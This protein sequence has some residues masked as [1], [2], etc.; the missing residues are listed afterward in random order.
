M[1]DDRSSNLSHREAG[2]GTAGEVEVITLPIFVAP[3]L[4]G[5]HN[6]LRP[7]IDPIACWK[8]EDMLFEFNSSFVMPTMASQSADLKHLMDKHRGAPASVYGHTDPTGTDDFNKPLSG[9][10]AQAVYGMLTRRIDLWEELFTKEGWGEDAVDVML[11]ALGFE[12]IDHKAGVA[13]FQKKTGLTAS[14]NADKET[15]AELFAQ[16]MDFVCADE[17]GTPFKLD[18]T[19]F[20]G[21]G[22]DIDGKADYQGCSEFNPVLVFSE[23]EDSAFRAAPD[24]TERDKANAPNRR[25][26][27]FLFRKGSRIDPEEWPCPRVKEGTALCKKRFWSDEKKRRQLTAERREFDTTGDTFACRFYER[28]STDSPCDSKRRVFIDLQS[29]DELGFFVPNA[30]LILVL[31]DGSR[32]NVRTDSSGYRHQRN[33]PEGEVRILLPDGTAAKFLFGRELR[34]AVLD[35]SVANKTITRVV[36]KF[37]SKGQRDVLNEQDDLH[38]RKPVPKDQLES[39][40][41]ANSRQGV[42]TSENGEPNP[43]STRTEGTRKHSLVCVDNLTM[44]AA[45]KIGFDNVFKNERQTFFKVLRQWLGDRHPTALGRGYYVHLLGDQ[46]MTTCTSGGTQLA[47]SKLKRKPAMPMGAYAVFED[48]HSTL[49]VDMSNLSVTA[50]MEEIPGEPNDLLIDEIVA[51]EDLATFQEVQKANHGRVE[52]LYRFPEKGILALMGLVGG[53]GLLENYPADP[54]VNKHVHERNLEVVRFVSLVY[55]NQL[56]RY[57]EKVKEAEHEDDIRR[58]GPPPDPYTFPTPVNITDPQIRD[59]FDAA[60]RSSLRAWAAI[61]QQLDKIAGQ[62][63]E[64][65][66]FFRVKLKFK[67]FTFKAGDGEKLPFWKD[68][69]NEIAFE[70]NVDVGTDGVLSKGPVAQGTLK[71]GLPLPD[72]L[73]TRINRVGGGPGSVG[74][75]GEYNLKSGKQKSTFQLDVKAVKIEVSDDGNRKISLANGAVSEINPSTGEFGMGVKFDLSKLNKTAGKKVDVYVGLHFQ[76]LRDDTAMA[77]VGGVPGFFERRSVD[78]LLSSVIQWNDLRADEHMR[79]TTLGWTQDQWDK[80]RNLTIDQFPKSASIDFDDLPADQQMALL[81]LGI[82]KFGGAQSHPKVWTTVAKK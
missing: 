74:L 10:R 54:E 21:H 53:T 31:P 63:A 6:T 45:N 41:K 44:V 32:R 13:D 42:P 62:H 3:T 67:P 22:D 29:V 59:L 64:G 58:L 16:Y 23:E 39:L 7:A 65:A 18:A 24:K 1:A 33:I 12:A 60:S 48:V 26:V 69:L 72:G 8:A 40:P 78:E 66:M 51:D 5:R 15:R 77:F 38:V 2:S 52:I 75:K 47:L 35:T 11:T 17:T 68:M 30:D 9:N 43:A 80:K 73:Q 49:F 76:G 34:D 57:I 4:T 61:A 82:R 27:V 19:D 37:L 20:L 50:S 79:L 46:T 55:I 28:L 56:D 14:G 25:V 81:G 36:V 70:D 71:D